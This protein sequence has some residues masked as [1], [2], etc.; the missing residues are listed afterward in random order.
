MKTASALTG[1]LILAGTACPAG[2]QT[3][4][5]SGDHRL[6]SP[7][8]IRWAPGPP[9]LPKGA[10]AALLYGDPSKEGPFVLRLRFP[11]NYQIPPHRHPGAE[12]LTVVSG[13]FMLG[14]GE[15]ADKAKA[16]AMPSGGFTAM[17]PNMAHYAHTDEV[18]V[19]QINSMGPW[20]INYVNPNDDPR[21]QPQ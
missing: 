17:P 10:E 14:S 9:S 3:A 7:Q 19:V 6:Y 12:I 20:S 13:T 11:A 1:I 16:Q 4:A 18:T 2:A 21:R 8:E 5:H 15:T